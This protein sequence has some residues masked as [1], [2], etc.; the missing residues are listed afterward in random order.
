MRVMTY[1]V[2]SFVASVVLLWLI[3]L[4]LMPRFGVALHILILT[5]R[6]MHWWWLIVLI[7]WRLVA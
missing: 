5:W 4:C 7:M 2:A 3:V 1:K 6:S